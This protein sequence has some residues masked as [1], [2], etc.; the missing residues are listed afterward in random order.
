MSR[1][2]G[3]SADHDRHIDTRRDALRQFSVESCLRA[4]IVDRY[5]KDFTRAEVATSN[6]EI[7]GGETDAFAASQRVRLVSPAFP[8]R[9]D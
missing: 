8:P 6:R 9:I 3:T 7:F 5:E 2:S 1:M 4:V